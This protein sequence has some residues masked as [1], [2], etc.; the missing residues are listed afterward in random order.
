[1]AHETD[2]NRINKG[3]HSDQAESA[4]ISLITTSLLMSLH[5]L[6]PYSIPH[7]VYHYPSLTLKLVRITMLVDGTS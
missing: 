7:S 4:N 2:A 1:M 5:A 3:R 6:R